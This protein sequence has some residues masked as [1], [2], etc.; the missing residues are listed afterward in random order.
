VAMPFSVH[1]MAHIFASICILQFATAL[2]LAVLIQFA[3][4][5]TIFAHYF[6]FVMDDHAKRYDDVGGVAYRT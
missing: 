5:V 2:R 1:E 3:L 6:V 4:I